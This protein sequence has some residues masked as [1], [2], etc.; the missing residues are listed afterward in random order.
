MPKSH[1]LTNTK[2][3]RTLDDTPER[4]SVDQLINFVVV[5]QSHSPTE[6]ASST[7]INVATGLI[8]SSLVPCNT[9]I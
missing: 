2:K 6:K 3:V 5:P 8:R 1:G 4:G 7:L 9:M